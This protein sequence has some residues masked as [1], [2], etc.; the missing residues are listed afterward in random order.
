MAD[1]RVSL[2]D[3]PWLCNPTYPAG[4]RKEITK[5]HPGRE[6][7]QRR[8]RRQTFNLHAVELC[9]LVARFGN[10]RLQSPIIRQHH[11][12]FGIGIQPP[13]SIYLGDWNVIGQGKPPMP[14]GKLGQHATRLVE[15][16]ESTQEERPPPNP[17]QNRI[18]SG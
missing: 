7:L 3:I 13:G 18:D 6:L 14:I 4:P 10:S 12:A 15:Q 16:Y 1:R 9:Q 11:Q 17:L 5:I 8:I 2:P